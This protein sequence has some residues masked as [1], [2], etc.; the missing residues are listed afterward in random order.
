MTKEQERIVAHVA[1]LRNAEAISDKEAT[2]R[3]WEQIT[4][5]NLSKSI[6]AKSIQIMATALK[7]HLH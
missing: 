2:H 1:G 5:G 4:L 3:I 7:C 6:D